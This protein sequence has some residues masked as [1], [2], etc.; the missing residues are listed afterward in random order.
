MI[1]I[2][3]TRDDLAIMGNNLM[4]TT[5]RNEAIAMAQKTVAAQLRDPRHAELL[6]ALPRGAPE[7]VH[8]PDEQPGRWPRLTELRDRIAGRPSSNGAG[9]SRG[10]TVGRGSDAA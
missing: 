2:Q 3:P 8:R 4:A 10:S 5:R 9:A 1:L 6:A 7:K